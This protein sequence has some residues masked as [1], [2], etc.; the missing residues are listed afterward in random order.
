[1]G[2]DVGNI[3]L[4]ERI[5]VE[6]EWFFYYKMFMIKVFRFYKDRVFVYYYII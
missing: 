1:M 5:V 6:V 3:L 2:K 4:S